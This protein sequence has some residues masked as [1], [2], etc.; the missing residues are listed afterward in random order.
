MEEIYETAA[1]HGKAFKIVDS[2]VLFRVFLFKFKPLPDDK[3]IAV[4]PHNRIVCLALNY[5]CLGH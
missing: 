2:S 3:F 1:I 4:F 5:Y